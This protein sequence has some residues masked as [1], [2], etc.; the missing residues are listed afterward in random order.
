MLM[1]SALF[2]PAL[3]ST[4]YRAA[5]SARAGSERGSARDSRTQLVSLEACVRWGSALAVSADVALHGAVLTGPITGAQFESLVF[6]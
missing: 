1:S 4:A 3:T 6:K 5:C 2:K